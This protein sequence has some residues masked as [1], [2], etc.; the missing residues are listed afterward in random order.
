MKLG[1]KV[2]LGPSHTVLDGTQLPSPK[3]VQPPIFGP[4]LL[5]PNGWMDYDATWCGGRPRPRQHCVRWE[6]INGGTNFGPFVVAK[7]L[8]GS[9]CHLVRR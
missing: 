7:W 1:M 5:W 2:G 8:D 6:K 9:I 4:C 3:G